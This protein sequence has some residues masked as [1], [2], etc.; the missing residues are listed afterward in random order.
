LAELERVLASHQFRTSKKCSRFLGHIVQA[1]LEGRFDRLKERTLGI[2]VF[3]REPHYEANQDP[4]VRGTAGEIRKRLAQYS[5]PY[6]ARAA[7]LEPFNAATHYR[8]GVLYRE[9]GRA[10]DAHRELGNSRSS[11]R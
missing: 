1:A 5:E 11:G 10:D 8:L 7:T 3:G 9:L 6:L 4:I 2:D